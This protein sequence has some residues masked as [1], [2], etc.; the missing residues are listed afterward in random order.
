MCRFWH[1]RRRCESAPPTTTSPVSTRRRM[2][3]SSMSSTLTF[4]AFSPM[5]KRVGVRMSSNGSSASP[6]LPV[7]PVT[8]NPRQ[9][10]AVTISSMDTWH[11]MTAPM[12]Q[13]S[14]TMGLLGYWLLHSTTRARTSDSICSRTVLASLLSGVIMTGTVLAMWWSCALK[15]RILRGAWGMLEGGPLGT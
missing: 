15:K 14:S 10:F 8:G 7:A 11:A 3:M 6:R 4:D 5:M 9:M 13:P 1:E 12:P 2:R